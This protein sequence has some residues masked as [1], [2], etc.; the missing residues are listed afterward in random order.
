MKGFSS[1]FVSNVQEGGGLYRQEDDNKV[2]VNYLELPLNLE[3]KFSA[4]RHTDLFIGFG[5]YFAAAVGGKIKTE[6]TRTLL[7]NEN[8]GSHTVA[9]RHLDIGT[10]GIA[11][12]IKPMDVGLNF[13]AGLECRSG[14]F[15]RVNFGMGVANISPDGND[16]NSLR[17]FGSSL[18]LGYL[19]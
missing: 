12:D 18:S 5:P 10:N 3:F 16:N 2:R 14:L 11:D 8:I 7:S 9:E 6:R 4:L 15:F 13:N 19:F 1:H 17:N